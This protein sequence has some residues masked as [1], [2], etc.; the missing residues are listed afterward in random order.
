ME[1][2]NTLLLTVIAVATLLVAVVGATFA[3]FTAQKGTG[4]NANVNVKTSTTDSL[5][6]NA[7][8]AIS[9]TA[10]QA[11]FA[12]GL[13]N[14]TGVNTSTVT[15]VANAD[16]SATYC[17]TADFIVTANTF[18][19]SALNNGHLPEL[20]VDITKNGTAVM[21]ARD[22]TTT[23]ASTI[24]VPTVNAG[25]VLKHPIN[26]AAGATTTDSW[27]TTVTLVNLAVDQQENTGKTF[28]G[29]I[30]FTTVAC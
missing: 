27:E 24:N 30:T 11:N 1:K 3:F 14:R 6:Y 8:T 5:V 9:I 7:G 4:A 23:G 22:I 25:A 29:T 17:Y 26:A 20:K 28:A 13:G 19:Y 2:K 12:E 16:T 21:T 10:T 15:L 18:E